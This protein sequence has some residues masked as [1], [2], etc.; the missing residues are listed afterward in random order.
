MVA[1]A[2]VLLVLASA[3]PANAVVTVSG[4]YISSD[5]AGDYIAVSR[6]AVTVGDDY[7]HLLVNAPARTRAAARF[8][9]LASP[10]RRR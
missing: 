10:R 8:V 1:P 5:N 6:A 7:D 2:A 9:G 4:S 3:V